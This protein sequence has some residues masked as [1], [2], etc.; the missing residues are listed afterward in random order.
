MKIFLSYASQDKAVAE[1]IAFSLR[2]SGHKVF[3]DRDNLPPAESYDQQI[4][5]A[6]NSS[7]VFVFLISPDS[8]ADG[9][10]SRTELTFARRKWPDPSGRVLP[11]M[12]R[13]TPLEEV[14]PY[15]RAVS[16]LEPVGNITAETSSVVQNMRSM[17]RR[18][19]EFLSD[20]VTLYVFAVLFV[21]SRW[22]EALLT[23]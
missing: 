1:S 22:L 13:K 21:S 2:G 12:V 9:R 16:I 5:S 20:I 11:V 23:L 19:H 18:W 14:P 6:V 4:E 7:D 15:L 17:K 8:V 10:Y 3:L